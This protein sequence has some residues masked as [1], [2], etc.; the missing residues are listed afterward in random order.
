MRVPF[1]VIG[2]GLSGLAAAIRVARFIP[3]VTLLEQ[4]SHLGGLNS[5]FYR[6]KTLFETGLHAIT[7]YAEAGNKKAPLN[8]LLRQLKLSRKDITFCQQIQ[9]EVRFPGQQSLLFSND[10][11]LLQEEV[12]SK[13]PQCSDGFRTLLQYLSEFNPF[14]SAPFRSAKDFLLATLKDPLLVDM[15]MCPLMYYGSSVENDMDISQFAIMFQAIYQEGMFRPE[16]TIKDFLDLLL[17]H[18]KHFGGETRLRSKVSS[19]LHENNQIRGVELESGEIIECDFLLSTIGHEETLEKLSRP[20]AKQKGTRLG[21]IESIYQLPL[22]SRQLLP[23]DRTV[24]FFNN[25]ENFSYQA[26]TDFAD[27]RSGVICLPYNFQGFEAKDHIEVRSTHL[28]SYDKWKELKNNTP[29]EYNAIKQKISQGSLTVIQKLIGNFSENIVYENTFTPL[30]IERYTAKRKGAVYGSPTKIK[31]GD[32][33]FN[34]LFLAG[35][36]QGFLGIVGSML[37][38][39]S[40]VNQHILPKF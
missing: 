32:I 18:Y 10:F 37:S 17:A 20:V 28:A 16:G 21:F 30:T 36:D 5:Y 8:R 6:N 34:N 25:A 35:T 3:G 1:L 33:G 39:V 2:G 11:L 13:F 26:P 7:N 22:A 40:M 4:H 15:L 29:D 23:T 14:L 19:I 38:G 27:L 31:D 12:A 9:S 24:L